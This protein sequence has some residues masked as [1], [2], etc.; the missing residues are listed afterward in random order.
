VK[1]PGFI[2]HKPP[3]HTRI[4][5]ETPPAPRLLLPFFAFVAFAVLFPGDLY[6]IIALWVKNR[7]SG[8]GET[9]PA[10]PSSSSS[11]KILHSYL[12]V[13]LQNSGKKVM[14]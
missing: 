12:R 4:S 14:F 3:N 1:H 5:Q 9:P 7:R 2:L 13:T 6:S 11:V 8:P 10:P